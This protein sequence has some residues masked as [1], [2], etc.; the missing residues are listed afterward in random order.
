MSDDPVTWVVAGLQV[1][2]AVG[3]GVYWITW[4]REEHDEA[5]LPA[6]FIDHETP[7]VFTDSILAV[8]LVVG[9]ILQVA[10]QSAGTSL[11]LIAAGMLLF[12]GVLDFAYFART[13]MFQRE[14]GGF[15][16]AFVVGSVLLVCVVLVVRFF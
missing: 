7:F 6:G 12:L 8:V 3:I 16:N 4:L 15:G 9:A 2:L 11:G 14:R 5:S 10:E 1:A 13:G